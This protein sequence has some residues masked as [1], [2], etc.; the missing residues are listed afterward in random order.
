[1]SLRIAMAEGHSRRFEVFE[2]ID[3]F[4]VRSADLLADAPDP[5]ALKMFRTATAAFAYAELAACRDRLESSC[6]ADDLDDED[7]DEYRACVQRFEAVR[8][9][10]GDD[11]IPA[12]LLEAWAR[13]EHAASQRHTH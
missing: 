12:A 3:G 9:K 4:T 5:E 10:L 1:M 11:G 2:S 13:V 6:D 7:V 8:L